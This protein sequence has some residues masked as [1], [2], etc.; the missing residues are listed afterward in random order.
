MN[1]LNQFE[2]FK[3]KKNQLSNNRRKNL[4]CWGIYYISF[5]IGRIW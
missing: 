4:S 3:P 5:E 1:S 2:I